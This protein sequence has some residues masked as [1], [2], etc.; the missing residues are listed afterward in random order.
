MMASWTL[1]LSQCSESGWAE[2][3]RAWVQMGASDERGLRRKWTPNNSDE[4]LAAKGLEEGVRSRG[5]IRTTTGTPWPQGTPD[6]RLID[7]SPWFAT[8]G[9][10]VRAPSGL[11]MLR[12]TRQSR[13]GTPPSV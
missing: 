2:D 9:S 3:P 10:G 6:K 12:V 7:F 5:T 13:A 1:R 4:E 11:P 8:R